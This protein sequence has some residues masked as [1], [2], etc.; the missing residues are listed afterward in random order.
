MKSRVRATVDSRIS[1]HLPCGNRLQLGSGFGHGGMDSGQLCC[2]RSA[3]SLAGLANDLG[4]LSSLPACS[5]GLGGGGLRQPTGSSE[6]AAVF[7]KRP[8]SRLRDQQEE[9]LP[10]PAPRQAA[11][12]H[13]PAEAVVLPY[14]TL[15]QLDGRSVISVK[16]TGVEVDGR[17][18]VFGRIWRF[19]R[20]EAVLAFPCASRPCWPLGHLMV[21]VGQQ[22]L[23]AHVSNDVPRTVPST[24]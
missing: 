13:S 20:S 15:P 2:S 18:R 1:N 17:T 7:R 11:V 14:R 19:R 22:A 12:N 21:M 5:K 3:R 23:V 24:T 6:L 10:V 16:T 9:R 8:C 4:V